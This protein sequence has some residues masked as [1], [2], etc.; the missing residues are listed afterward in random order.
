MILLSI[1][2]SIFYPVDSWQNLLLD[3][4]QVRGILMTGVPGIRPYNLPYG[5][6]PRFAAF[7]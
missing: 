2:L 1:L 7:A 3:E 6:T 4:I 5:E